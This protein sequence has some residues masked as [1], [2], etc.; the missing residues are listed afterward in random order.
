MT[1]K[2]KIPSTQPWINQLRFFFGFFASDFI[3]F[4]STS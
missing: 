2:K 1:T 4:G 3:F